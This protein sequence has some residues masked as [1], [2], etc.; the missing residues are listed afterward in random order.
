MYY[1]YVLQS[2]KDKNYYTGWTVDLRG[3]LK[4][5]NDGKVYSTRLREPLEVIYY[6]ACLNK[7]DATQRE[8]YLKSG[9]GKR[10]LKIRLKQ[11]RLTG[12]TSP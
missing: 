1:T 6:E 10:Y 3:R 4:Q 12:R 5:H 8:K 2:S 11:W 9:I 7:D